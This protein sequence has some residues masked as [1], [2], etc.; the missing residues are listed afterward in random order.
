MRIFTW[1]TFYS[2]FFVGLSFLFLWHLNSR[3]LLPTWISPFDM[4]LVVLA[5]FRLVRL[6]VYDTITKFFRDWLNTFEKDSF[7]GTFGVLLHC[8]WCAGLWFALFVSYFYFLT[9]YAWFFIFFLAVGG[10]ASFVQVLSRLVKWR[11]E[12]EK[13]L[14]TKDF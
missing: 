14:A 13:Y 6:V 2:L 12:R 8:P 4:L 3:G 9:P 10:L 11:V 5:T 1:N 7:W